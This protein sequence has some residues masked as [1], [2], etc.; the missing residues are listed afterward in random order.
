MPNDS[1]LSIIVKLQ[2]DASAGL[3]AMSE[4]MKAVGETI[5]N[6]TQTAQQKMTA[7]GTS[8]ESL[9]SSMKSAG[10]SMTLGLTLPI[11]A[12]GTSALESSMKFSAAMELIRTQAGASQTE[13]D[14][15]T[16]S[17]LALA[18][19][20]QTG[21]GPQ[22][23]AD[24]LYHLESLGLRGS[25]AM[26]ALKISA[27][28]ADVGIA[29]MEGVTNAL[30]AA[31]VTGIKGTENMGDAMGLLNA[32]IGQGNMK[33]NDLVAALGTGILPAAKNFGLSLQDVGAALA[34]LTDNGM[35]ADESATRLRM[36]FS[37]MAAPTKKA[38]SAFAELGMG[39]YQLADDM[40]NGGIVQA[41]DDLNTHLKASGMTATQ[42]AAI[43]SQAFGG[44]RTSAA[45]LTLTEQADRLKTKYDAIGASAGKFAED[46]AA[47]DQT[48][49][50]KLNA[51]LAQYQATMIDIGVTAM[52]LFIS[53]LQ[54][55]SVLL[56]DFV[57]WWDK[58]NP[59]TKNFILI[60][61]GIVAV[62]GPLLVI[63]GS[64]ISAIGVVAVAIGGITVAGLA[65]AGT[66]L[67]VIGILAGLVLIFRNVYE[68]TQIV[69]GYLIDNWPNALAFIA[70][71]WKDTWQ[72]IETFFEGIATAIFDFFNK[73]VVVPIQNAINAIIAAFN[74]MKAIV[75]VPISV[76]S[77]AISGVGSFIG[78]AVS[79]IAHHESGGFVNAP[80]GTAVPIIAHG[81]EEIITAEN[82]SGRG[83]GGSNV[84]V[85]INNPSVRSISDIQEL[86]RQIDQ[87]MRPL[88][89]NAKIV[90]I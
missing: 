51:L 10:M 83:R 78:N 34:T 39:A 69:V 58:L 73:T 31:L 37:L 61:L 54:K 76:V 47:T 44:G 79:S 30:G 55:V 65:M 21:Q 42:Q 84:Y 67:V 90:H 9:G 36:T 4:K 88:L 60:T 7:F 80:R 56:A 22:K 29:D 85:T 19:S 24:G 3:A 17:V 40:R 25:V 43:L 38:Q 53:L 52:P 41:V 8:M 68:I 57:G 75:S 46:V 72:N 64:V 16:K 49:Q 89:V 11:V 18:E 63:L 71:M 14:N 13:V 15:M 87:V 48:P 86:R 27:Q 20:G 1:T 32:T 26:D 33:M 81:G 82:S 2:D 23:L 59:A 6:A 28:A 50:M 62:L 74:S 5:G 45:I 35:R 77:N 70:K 12:I 66:V